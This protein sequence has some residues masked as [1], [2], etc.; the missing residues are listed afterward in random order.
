MLIRGLKQNK[1]SELQQV[2][3]M[4]DDAW[5]NANVNGAGVGD[6]LSD[7]GDDNDG[8]GGHAVDDERVVDSQR[9]P[10]DHLP[11][12][13][14]LIVDSQYPDDPIEYPDTQPDDPIEDYDAQFLPDQP[15]GDC[16]ENDSQLP[17]EPVEYTD[18]QY[19]DEPL[20]NASTQVPEEPVLEDCMED[21]AY[22]CHKPLVAEPAFEPDYV[23]NF[24]MPIATHPRQT[25]GGSQGDAPDPH[26]S[27][28]NA[29]EEPPKDE[30]PSSHPSSAGI[31]AVSSEAVGNPKT[32]PAVVTPGQTNS[33]L[34]TGVVHVGELPNLNL[35]LPPRDDPAK[36]QIRQEILSKIRQVRPGFGSS[37]YCLLSATCITRVGSKNQTSLA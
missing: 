24:I 15:P 13:P 6:G 9:L 28:E 22:L 35:Q 30:M 11:D 19:L 8:S 26:R 33:H 1:A 25:H 16:H 12:E 7:P 20:E 17:D 29:T 27:Q 2:W 32:T 23:E 21:C 14:I 36:D 31:G 3:G 37:A 18:S 10:D 4:L 34:G 5:G